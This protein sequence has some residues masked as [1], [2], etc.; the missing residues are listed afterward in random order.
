MGD[1]SGLPRLPTRCPAC[2]GAV[3]QR[4][5]RSTPGTFIWFTCLFCSHIWKFRIDDVPANPKGEVTGTIFVI[6]KGGRKH[7]LGS[8]VVYAIPEDPLKKHLQGKTKEGELETRKLQRDID[9]LTAMLRIANAEEDRLWKILQRDEGNPRK[10]DAW[11]F[12]YNKAKTTTQQIED[13]QARRQHLASG[14]YFFDGLPSGISTAKTDADGKFKLVIPRRGR[15]GVVASASR[16]L[17]KGK[18]TYYW[19]VWVNLDGEASK[20]LRLSN[21]N[22]MGAGSPDSALQ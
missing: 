20:R 21:E 9:R 2:K 18:E 11:R 5:P 1:A 22:M 3:I 6:T 16:E 15:H 10:A 17:L 12:V 14:E 19:F 13:L 4:I 8:A 7:R